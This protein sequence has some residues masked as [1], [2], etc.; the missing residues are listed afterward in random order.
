MS[1]AERVLK[2]RPV[3]KWQL[4]LDGMFG[5]KTIKFGYNKP[6]SNHKTHRLWLPN[7]QFVKLYSETLGKSTKLKVTTSCLRTI[8]KK[9]GLDNY[10]IKTKD[11]EIGGKTALAL[12][13]QILAAKNINP[14]PSPLTKTKTKAKAIKN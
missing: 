11:E 5:G 2:V 9:G 1:L 8:D 14:R 10:L 3:R 13:A 4:S 7:I 12:K 6:K